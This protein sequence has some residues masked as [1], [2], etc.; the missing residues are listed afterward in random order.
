MHGDQGWLLDGPLQSVA[1][2]CVPRHCDGDKTA[3]AAS[4]GT[5]SSLRAVWVVLWFLSTQAL[6]SESQGETSGAH[7]DTHP[8]HREDK[9]GKTE[10]LKL[11]YRENE[12]SLG[13]E[14]LASPTA[15][16]SPDA[17]TDRRK[18]YGNEPD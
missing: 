13:E 2:R 11:K 12:A 9:A 15:A 4:A 7:L 5:V 3:S 16:L 1:A 17:A 6:C 14:Q 18:C 10:T 8:R